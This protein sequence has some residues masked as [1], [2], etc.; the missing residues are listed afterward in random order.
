MAC[1]ACGGQTFQPVST[2]VPMDLDASDQEQQDAVEKE[3]QKDKN[4]MQLDDE[5][6]GF[7]GDTPV[8]VLQ[9]RFLRIIGDVAVKP[10]PIGSTSRP[11]LLW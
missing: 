3:V 7:D 8:E 11:Q 10:P 6:A 5:L 9:G 2:A 1:A 4:D